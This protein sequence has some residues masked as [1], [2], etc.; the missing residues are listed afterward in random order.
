M[1]FT[2]LFLDWHI[3]C[4]L[5]FTDT[6][7]RS[8]YEAIS[9]G[10]YAVQIFLGNPKSF[11]RSIVSFE[12]ILQTKRL[13]TRYPVH[14]FTHFPYVANLAGSVNSLAWDGDE[15]QDR[16]TIFL[17]KNL[18]YEL[19]VISNFD[20][21]RNGVVIHPGCYKDRSKGLKAISTSINKINFTENSKL[22]L[23]NSA[24][25]GNSLA[26]T[27]KEIGTIIQGVDKSKRGNVGVCIDTAHIWGMG[28][29]DISTTQGIDKLFNDFDTIIGSEYLTLVHLNDSEVKLG[30]RV[31]RHVCLG[32]GYI[33]GDS[34]NSLIH[35]L[36]VCQKRSIPCVLETHPNDILTVS[37]LNGTISNNE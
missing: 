34:F 21:W 16:K 19:S 17:L 6:I 31:D 37:S 15:V 1:E 29:Y 14:V 11:K 20:T 18:E 36:Q 28:E 23:E 27:L 7:Q 5:S 32:Q 24:G 10:M 9:R 35:L 26:T 33:W 4:H 30:S 12:D 8:V 22:L 25:Q 13:L 3:G 2:Q